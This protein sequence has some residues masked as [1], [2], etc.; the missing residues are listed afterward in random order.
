MLSFYSYEG[1]IE[2]F[3]TVFPYGTELPNYSCVMFQS[4]F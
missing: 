3:Y 4:P 1:G 2:P